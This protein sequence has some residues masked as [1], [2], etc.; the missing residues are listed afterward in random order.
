M[1]NRDLIAK[2]PSCVLFDVLL[3]LIIRCSCKCMHSFKIAASAVVP[4][5][6]SE[7]ASG[8]L[9]MAHPHDFSVNSPSIHV[10]TGSPN[11]LLAARS[12]FTVHLQFNRVGWGIW[13][14]GFFPQARIHS[15]RAYA[16]THPHT[17]L[18]WVR[19]IFLFKNFDLLQ[20]LAC[21]VCCASLTGARARLHAQR[22][23]D[24]FR[25]R[26]CWWFIF[27]A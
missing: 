20:I 3:L 17:P 1:L 9:L 10:S 21:N 6:I 14:L 24:C 19:H 5:I 7:F 4:D 25:C 16:S 18:F 22:W 8:L 27:A 11:L 13:Q 26:Y 23:N 12:L 15:R 2:S